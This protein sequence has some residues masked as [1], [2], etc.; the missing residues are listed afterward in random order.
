MTGL[1]LA[2]SNGHEAVVRLLL[3]HGAEV[4]AAKQVSGMRGRLHKIHT[5]ARAHAR[6]HTHTLTH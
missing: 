3:E 4:D 2:A 6:T 1:Y 5:R